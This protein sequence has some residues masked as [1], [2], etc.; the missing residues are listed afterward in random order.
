MFLQ[1][2]RDQHD[3]PSED[4]FAT[5]LKLIG[6]RHGRAPL[7]YRRYTK[8]A[9]RRRV[10]DSRIGR[11]DGLEAACEPVDQKNPSSEGVWIKTG[12]KEPGSD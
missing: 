4:Q 3:W 12:S 2:L 6:I 7:L 10:I 9:S 11:S 1:Q 8:P 5:W